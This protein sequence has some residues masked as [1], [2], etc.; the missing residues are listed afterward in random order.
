MR[1]QKSSRIEPK[2]MA[3]R[4]RGWTPVFAQSDAQTKAAAA[5]PIPI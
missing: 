2:S 4:K 3:P 1:K 5:L